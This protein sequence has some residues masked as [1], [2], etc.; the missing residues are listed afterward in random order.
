MPPQEQIKGTAPPTSQTRSCAC[1][2]W[3]LH[4]DSKNMKKT[5]KYRVVTVVTVERCQRKQCH[6]LKKTFP[7]K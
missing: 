1:G 2:T 7:G 5:T 3:G 4:D 6:L